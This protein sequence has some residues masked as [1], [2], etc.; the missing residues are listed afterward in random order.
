MAFEWFFD[1]EEIRRIHESGSAKNVK[2]KWVKRGYQFQISLYGVLTDRETGES[3]Y[4]RIEILSDT[5]FDPETVFH[6]YTF[7]FDFKPTR[8]YSIWIYSKHLD[9]VKLVGRYQ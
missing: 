8:P 2:R 4:S 1:A 9:S 7:F 5:P 6:I 3:G